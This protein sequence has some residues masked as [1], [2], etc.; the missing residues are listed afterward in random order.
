MKVAWHTAHNVSAFFL[1]DDF[2]ERVVEVPITQY[3]YL[4]IKMLD[5]NYDKKFPMA[6]CGFLLLINCLV[7]NSENAALTLQRKLKI[8]K[9]AFTLNRL[10]SYV[11]L[12]LM[13]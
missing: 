11:Q 4:C 3:R 6:L 5:P 12:A 1:S 9:I 8:E 10:I 2:R 7:S 13:T